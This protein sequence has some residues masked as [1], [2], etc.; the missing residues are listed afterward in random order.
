MI[1]KYYLYRHIRLDKN[2]PFYIGVGTK[3][4]Q[5]LV[6]NTYRRAFTKGGRKRLWKSIINKISYEVEIIIE[7][8]DYEFILEKEIE[9][10]KLY[11][12]IDKK[13]GI[14]A[15]HTDGG[16]G[17]KNRIVSEETRL[18]I[19][20]SHKGK[21]ISEEQKERCRELRLGSTNSQETRNKISQGNKKRGHSG[22]NHS[23]AIKIYQYSIEGELLNSW[24]C[25]KD[26]ERTLGIRTSHI[27]ECIKRDV[28]FTRGFFWSKDFLGSRFLFGKIKGCRRPISKVDIF[29]DEILETYSSA[30][31]AS[32]ALV[33]SR[34]AAHKIS[35]VCKDS[36]DS[37]KGFK[38]K[39]ANDN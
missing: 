35:Q 33:G 27:S 29:T 31:K 25:L 13:T 5:D 34:N 11:G 22:A 6:Y 3:C 4:K 8:N 38:W 37:Y 16:E 9:F 32:E 23:R 15:N 26:I 24:A 14:L 7:S 18:K 20:K 39:F 17:V 10:I 21:I 1:N 36:I 12:R 19:S 30:K 28:S 2:E